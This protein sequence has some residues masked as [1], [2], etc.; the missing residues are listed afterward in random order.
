MLT[1]LL[2]FVPGENSAFLKLFTGYNT[3]SRWC[4][5]PDDSSLSCV[6]KAETDPFWSFNLPPRCGIEGV[7]VEYRGADELTDLLKFHLEKRLKPEVLPSAY[8]DFKHS[9][10]TSTKVTSFPH[11]LALDVDRFAQKRRTARDME[12]GKQPAYRDDP[13]RTWGIVLGVIV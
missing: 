6:D 8:C 12:E 9:Q 13:V 3:T 7:P 11:W 5:P 4:D 1:H 2:L 10:L